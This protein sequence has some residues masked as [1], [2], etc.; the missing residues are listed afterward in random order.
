MPLSALDRI[1]SLPAEV[2]SLATLITKKIRDVIAQIPLTAVPIVLNPLKKGVSSA[3]VG[4]SPNDVTEPPGIV[5]V[6]A[7]AVITPQANAIN[8]FTASI[9]LFFFIFPLYF[10]HLQKI[11]GGEIEF[12]LSEKCKCQS[13]KSSV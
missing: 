8:P 5:M 13:G 11:W 2:L 7:W 9:K 10:T 6:D 3:D 4:A 1:M 12:L